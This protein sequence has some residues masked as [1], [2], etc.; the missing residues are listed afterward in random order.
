MDIA[1]KLIS[2][3]LVV[4]TPGK[5]LTKNV[6]ESEIIKLCHRAKEVLMSQTPFLELD[7]PMRIC[8]DIHGQYSGKFLLKN[9][10]SN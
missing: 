1:D 6:K 7:V 10:H 3:L 8:G 2:K 5:Q 9:L 4:G